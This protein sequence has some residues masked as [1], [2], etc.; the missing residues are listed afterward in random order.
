M[1]VVVIIGAVASASDRRLGDISGHHDVGR[2]LLDKS[3]SEHFQ[4]Q[5][6]IRVTDADRKWT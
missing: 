5:I 2:G 6:V 1:N 4:L 3:T